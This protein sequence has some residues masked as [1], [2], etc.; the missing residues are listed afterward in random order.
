MGE[1]GTVQSIK[2]V[3]EKRNETRHF[4]LLALG[5]ISIKKT[6]HF[7]RVGG[8]DDDEYLYSTFQPKKLTHPRA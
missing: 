3:G 5:R 1:E 2:Q 7:Q 6:L 8:D 4:S